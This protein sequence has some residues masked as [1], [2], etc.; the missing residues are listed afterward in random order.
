[1]QMFS[2]AGVDE[3]EKVKISARP[4]VEEGRSV[5]CEFVVF[6]FGC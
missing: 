4:F 5:P 1:M 2:N 3:G 6:F